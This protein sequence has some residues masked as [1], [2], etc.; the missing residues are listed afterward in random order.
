MKRPQSGLSLLE[1]LV[2]VAIMAMSL[3]L[4]YQSSLGALRGTSDLA[5]QQRATMLAQSLLDARDGVPAAGWHETGR[6]AEI[7]WRVVSAPVPQPAG[8][9]TNAPVLHEVTIV[10]Q[11][12]GREGGVRV[13]QLRTLLPQLRTQPGEAVR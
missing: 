8:L 4:I 10:L 6:S 11:W 1:L 5:W 13:M 12:P 7:D 9:S 2:A 3:G